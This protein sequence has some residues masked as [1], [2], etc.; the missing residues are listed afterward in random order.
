[1]KALCIGGAMIDT[2][3]IIE[4][5]R[6]ERMSMLNA[7]ASFLLIEEGR[8]TEA[9]EV[10]THCGGGARSKASCTSSPINRAIIGRRRVTASTR[11]TTRRSNTCWRLKASNWRV[12]PV[13]R[14]AAVRAMNRSRRV[15]PPFF[16][17]MRRWRWES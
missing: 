2:I 13:A 7:E 17:F 16:V 1:M 15:R 9:L 12:N 8:K 3:A 11:S 5:D 10:S 6:I 4:S 14:C